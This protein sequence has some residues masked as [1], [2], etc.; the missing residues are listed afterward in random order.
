MVRT[1]GRTCTT[2]ADAA[3]RLV[4][5]ERH[6]VGS[7][8]T[9]PLLPDVRHHSAD[10]IRRVHRY[11][12]GTA[13]HDGIQLLLPFAGMPYFYRE[14]DTVRVVT[15]GR[16][17]GV[18]CGVSED[19]GRSWVS[20]PSFELQLPAPPAQF[21]SCSPGGHATQAFQGAQGFVCLG[22]HQDR[23]G[24][25]ASK[26][27]S[28]PHLA[29]I[30]T[31]SFPLGDSNQDVFECYSRTQQSRT[32]QQPAATGGPL[33]WTESCCVNPG[34]DKG[35]PLA[36]TLRQLRSG[37]LIQPVRYLHWGGAHLQK[38]TK[39]VIGGELIEMYTENMHGHH[40]ELEAAYV[41]FSDDCGSSWKRSVGDVI[42]WHADGWGNIVTIDE[43]SVEELP[44]GQLLM[45]ARSLVG[46]LVLAFS[47]DSGEHWGM[48]I[49]SQLASDSAPAVLRRLPGGEVL[50]VWNQQ[51]ASEC[52]RGL[53]RC[54]LS[55]ALTRDGRHWFSFRTLEHHSSY[56]P[57]REGEPV[58]VEPQAQLVR[59][60]DDPGP[61]PSEFGN[62]S[63]P[64]VDVVDDHVFI[65][66]AHSGSPAGTEFTPDPQTQ[67]TPHRVIFTEGVGFPPFT[68]Y[69][70]RKVRILPVSWFYAGA[71]SIDT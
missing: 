3:G 19:G 53:R 27:N 32:Q 25:E 69:N 44:S 66:F 57:A 6:I 23:T 7:V 20:S 45:V 58:E 39:T 55:C 2:A 49:V 8:S 36:C 40:P 65:S 64:T 17:D 12:L 68:K 42:G 38:G 62:S 13:P 70:A 60:L 33:E 50:C 61:L 18:R 28:Q 11:L 24:E 71:G 37:R 52:R 22:R 34:H 41:Y 29:M 63:Y 35:A 26:E 56:V 51:S 21:S 5:M 30:W 59:A 4:R 9:P 15:A 31:R 47:D 67:T 14:G 1:A 46:R 16:E 54:R 10:A 43:P 48:P